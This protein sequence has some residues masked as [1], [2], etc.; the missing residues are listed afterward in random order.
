M[1]KT[2]TIKLVFASAILFAGCAFTDNGNRINDQRDALEDLEHKRESYETRYIIILNG[3]E[4]YPDDSQLEKE[5][6]S[7]R[8]RILEVDADI[9]VQ[10]DLFD[11]S[12]TEWEKK[13]ADDKLQKQIM[14][15]EDRINA[16]KKDGDLTP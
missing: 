2:F 5:R 4:K 13:I 6:D 1:K 12:V 3:L 15:R 11:Q 7:I 10:R 8:K 9:K 16:S 14:E